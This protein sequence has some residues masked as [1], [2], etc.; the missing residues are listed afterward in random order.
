MALQN[1]L[2]FSHKKC[3]IFGVAP[4][5]FGGGNHGDEGSLTRTSLGRRRWREREIF[6]MV[7]PFC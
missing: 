6:R 7:P 1:L 5:G 4:W 2:G 3:R